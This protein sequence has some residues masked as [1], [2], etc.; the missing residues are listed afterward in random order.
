MTIKY[1]RFALIPH[2]C[3]WCERAFVFEPYKRL[4]A[5]EFHGVGI[6]TYETNICKNCLDKHMSGK[7]QE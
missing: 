6:V 3:Y 4:S 2:T 7:E 1:N 5:E